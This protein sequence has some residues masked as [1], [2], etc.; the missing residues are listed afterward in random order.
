MERTRPALQ[1]ECRS[2]LIQQQ[3]NHEQ[4][5]KNAL[6]HQHAGFQRS[7][8]NFEAEARDVAQREVA[9]EKVESNVSKNILSAQMSDLR[10]R[11]QQSE[12]ETRMYQQRSIQEEGKLHIQIRESA[13]ADETLRNEIRHNHDM[14]LNHENEKSV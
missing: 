9:K 2:A 3:S 14:A 5:L 10:N 11:L 4:Y 6:E 7:A 8:Q 1:E 12:Q 13:Q